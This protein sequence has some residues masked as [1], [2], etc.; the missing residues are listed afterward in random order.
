MAKKILLP[1]N[2]IHKEYV[3]FLLKNRNNYHKMEE[4]DINN[5]VK[6]LNYGKLEEKDFPKLKKTKKCNNLSGMCF[7][8]IAHGYSSLV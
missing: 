4:K 7:S 6:L 1:I 8:K 5:L 3:L 2:K